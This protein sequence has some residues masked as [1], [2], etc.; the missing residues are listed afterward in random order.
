MSEKEAAT[1]EALRVAEALIPTG[2]VYISGGKERIEFDLAAL[3]DLLGLTHGEAVPLVARALG[4]T[5]GDDAPRPAAPPSL[6]VLGLLEGQR[7][8]RR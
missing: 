4:L 8:D 3:C 7:T 2:R 5:D 6:A 1:G